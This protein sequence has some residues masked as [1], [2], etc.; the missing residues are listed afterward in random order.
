[1]SSLGAGVRRRVL[2]ERVS[3][4]ELLPGCYSG[5]SL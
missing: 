5:E 2:W 4:E 3:E 1:M